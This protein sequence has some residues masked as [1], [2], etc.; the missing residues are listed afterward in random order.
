MGERFEQEFEELKTM[1]LD[2]GKLSTEMLDKSVRSLKNNDMEL[3]DWV[4]SKKG[5]IARM[6]DDIETRALRLLT[7]YQPVATDMRTI[8]CCLKLNTYLARVGRY[9]K[10]I[11]CV[12]KALKGK[13]HVSKLV[14][15]PYMAKLVTDMLNDALYS[16][17]HFDVSKMEDFSERDDDVDHLRWSIFRECLSYMMEEPKY[18]KQCANY[19]MVARYLERCGDNA[20]KMNEKIH[21]MVTGVRVE[22]D[23]DYTA[24]CCEDGG[25]PCQN[26]QEQ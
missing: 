2:M 8:A 20:C 21:Y 22:V 18:I 9:G 24:E 11:A 26:K 6:D 19:I 15:L 25:E 3:A 16:F 10:D 4:I 12:T 14:S 7:L 1:V 23:K 17:E 5:E 13:K